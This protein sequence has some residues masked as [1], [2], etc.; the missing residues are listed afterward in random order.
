MRYNRLDAHVAR[1]ETLAE[2]LDGPPADVW[3]HA[4]WDRMIAVSDGW[5][6]WPADWRLLRADVCPLCASATRKRVEFAVAKLVSIGCLAR[7]E[8]QTGQAYLFSPAWWRYNPSR[9]WR[10]MSAPQFPHPSS[11]PLPESLLGYLDRCKPDD[12]AKER[13]RLLLDHPCMDTEP[14]DETTG[15]LQG[16][17]LET[18]CSEAEA[19]AE[20]E[21]TLAA[22]AKTAARPKRKK[23]AK[24]NPEAEKPENE[25]RMDG[26]IAAWEAFGQRKEDMPSTGRGDIINCVKAKGLRVVGEWATWLQRN[27]PSLDPGAD[28]WSA[29][30]DRFRQAVMYR[31]FEGTLGAGKGAPAPPEPPSLGGKAQ[32]QARSKAILEDLEEDRRQA[33]DPATRAQIEAAIA[34]ARQKLPHRGDEDDDH[35]PA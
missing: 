12:R 1:S 18:T 22:P 26:I 33:E 23:A 29:F 9:D 4:F 10:C 34:A 27:P 8:T 3:T 20:A 15:T 6:I 19:E 17:S 14:A 24:K 21:N 7:A 32:D 28:P 11:R 5:G 30:R 31:R 35:A 25:T 2:L 16:D 13:T